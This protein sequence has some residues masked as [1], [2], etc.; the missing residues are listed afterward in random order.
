MFGFWGNVDTH[1]DF[2]GFDD[3]EQYDKYL[4]GGGFSDLY[5]LYGRHDSYST[6]LKY[7]DA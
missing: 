6:V 5:S 3:R 1:E 4:I 7:S 2:D